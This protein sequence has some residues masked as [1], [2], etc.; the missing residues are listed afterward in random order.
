[1]RLRAIFIIAVFVLSFSALFFKLYDLQ[2]KKS[3]I[4][5]LKAQAQNINSGFFAPR[6]GIIYFTDKNGNPAPAA[7][8]RLY[9]VL[10]A[11]PKQ[12]SDPV[13]TA[14]ILTPIIGAE[15]EVLA[16]KLSKPGDPYELLAS[17]LTDEQV[18]AFKAAAPEGVFLDR[19]EFRFYPA[20]TLAAHVLGFVGPSGDDD[21]ERGR[22]GLEAYFE[23]DLAGKAGY[24]ESGKLV[25]P[26]DGSDVALTIDR[27][28][29][30]QAEEILTKTIEANK[31]T[32]GTVIVQEPKTG[33]ILAFGNYPTFNPGSYAESAV[34]VFLN[35]GVQ[36]VYE[37]GSVF[38]I[39]TMA[40]GIDSGKITPDTVYTD[41]GSL[42]LNGKTIRNYDGKVYGRTT[43]AKVIENSINTGAAF[44]ESKTGHDNFYRYAVNFGFKSKTGIELPGEV[45]GSLKSLERDAR[46]INFATASFGQGAAVTPIELISAVSAI[47]NGGVLMRPYLVSRDDPETVRRVIKPE[48]AEQVTKMMVASV[49]KAKVAHIPNF[50]VAGKTGTAQIPDFKRG[51]YTEEFIHTFAGFAPAS[52]PRFT[53]L[54][55]I[56]KPKVGPL[57]GYTVVPAFRE[58]AEFMLNYLNIPPDNLP[59]SPA[60]SPE[61]E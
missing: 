9:P 51:G 59:P 29:Q 4:Y 3:E 34:S 38:K 16:R 50:K 60:V 24:E 56:D 55:K 32:S 19:E 58:L 48:T 52:N 61:D 49:Q 37:P 26:V 39:I 43:M 1:M 5:S 10:F 28:I 6:R 44:A 33:K 31:A 42:T 22:Y 12:I 40:A 2:I 18:A 35:P 11:V 20:E 25:G 36:S 14:E 23:N 57:A 47:A 27:T 17:K 7:M 53:I 13:R 21:K 46:D 54:F 41:T 8:N 15:K 30:A 45:S